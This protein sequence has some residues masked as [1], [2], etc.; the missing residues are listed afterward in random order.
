MPIRTVKV[1]APAGPDRDALAQTYRVVEPYEAFLLLEV[2]PHAVP[3]LSA[4]FPLE[5]VTDQY[6]IEV[7]DRRIDTSRPR[8]D[9]R[10]RVR[11]HPDYAPRERLDPGRHHYL[12][13][14]IGPIKAAWLDAVREA[15][16][17]PREPF[18]DFTYVVR[19]DA[20]AVKRVAGLAEVRWVGHLP[21]RTRIEPSV[22]AAA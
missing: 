7:A 3:E 16:G 10:G 1:F 11:P 5:D 15:G 6:A 12:V 14:F 18:G 22:L 9:R 8:V 2:P 21:H 20:R 13:Q 4:R 17:E 19:A